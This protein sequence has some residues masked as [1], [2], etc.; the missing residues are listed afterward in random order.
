M[1]QLI[2][3][4]TYL[5]DHSAPA[6]KIHRLLVN[7]QGRL[8]FIEDMGG[9][10]VE[11]IGSNH[12]LTNTNHNNTLILSDKTI[13]LNPLQ[14]YREG[15]QVACKNDHESSPSVISI[16]PRTGWT[17][18]VN[19]KPTFSVSKNFTLSAGGTFTVIRKGGEK[20]LL[21]DGDLTEQIDS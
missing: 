20:K 15:F 18:R 10:I 5:P 7:D 17:F 13:T 2:T 14:N 1:K 21:L 11:V 4:N 12:L 8:I 3:E 9:G 19:E 6:G 16:I